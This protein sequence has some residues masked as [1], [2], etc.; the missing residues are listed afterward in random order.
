MASPPAAVS[1]APP[2]VGAALVLVLLSVAAPAVAAQEESSAGVAAFELPVGARPIGMGRAYVAID[3]DLQGLLYN[4]AGLASRDSTGLTFSRYE[5]ASDLDLN[6]N[7]GAASLPVGRGAVT[8]A[9][10]YEDLGE[11]ELTGSSPEPLGTVDLRN[12]L[13]VGSYA[14]QLAPRFAVGASAKYL[15]SD[16]GVADGSG[17]AFDA[18][19]LI[20]PSDRVPLTLGL[21]VLN[22]GPDFGLDL[23]DGGTGDEPEGDPLP[24][25]LRWGAA[26]DLR[27]VGGS[28]ADE[29]GDL[30]LT[31]AA[32]LEH[33]L[34]ELGTVSLFGGAALGYRDILTIRGGVLR[35][36]NGFGEEAS[37]GAS[38][39]AGVRWEGIRAD[40]AREL[41]VNEAG[42][43]THFSLGVDF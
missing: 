42:D 11:I 7:Y 23:D 15:S 2:G 34:R 43:E 37:S 14:V 3:G 36:E 8:V 32:D 20:R 39:G 33:D 21:A 28:G 30:G 26:V 17:V 27:N 19:V 12:V 4:P 40:V 9:L 24:S 31:L 25:R 1:T 18:G 6:G 38:L 10:N 41:G 13:L 35:L 16:L 5:G 29:G 22:V